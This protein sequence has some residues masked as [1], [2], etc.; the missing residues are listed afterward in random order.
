MFFLLMI[1][2]RSFLIL[3]TLVIVNYRLH[4]YLRGEKH[5]KYVLLAGVVFNLLPLVILKI[6]PGLMGGVEPRTLSFNVLLPIGLAFYALQQI[7]A[8]VDIYKEPLLKMSFWSYCFY[9]FFFLTL[10]SGPIF[11]YKE[12][13]SQ[14]HKRLSKRKQWYLAVK[15]VSLF[16][17]GLAKFALIASPISQHLTVFFTGLTTIEGLQLTLTEGIYIIIGCLISLYFSFSAFSDMAIGLAMCFGLQ[18]P[19][20]FDSPLKASTPTQYINTWHMSFIQFIRLYVFQPTFAVC[21]KLPINNFEYKIVFAWSCAVFFSFFL[22]GAWHAPTLF[23]MVQ[24]AIVALLIVVTQ[25]WLSSSSN[26]TSHISIN[27]LASRLL[28]HILIFVTALFFF[29]PEIKVATQVLNSVIMPTEIS[30]SAYMAVINAYDL[31]NIMTFNGFFPNYAGFPMAWKDSLYLPSAGLSLAHLI[32]AFWVAVTMP[33]TMQIF[34]LQQSR[35]RS[36]ID[37]RWRLSYMHIMLLSV[38]FYLSIDALGNGQA[39]TYG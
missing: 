24:S 30:L 17:V 38:M 7:T 15:G 26:I 28:T 33:N 2:V 21:K 36:A 20:N 29:S 3:I 1:D 10:I 27:K 16:I 5:R 8:L 34:E 18:L 6:T 11:R 37:L 13:L 4:H 14:Y 31:T 23:M 35:Y 22:T 39:F 9:S 19:I 25:L 32:C 12:A